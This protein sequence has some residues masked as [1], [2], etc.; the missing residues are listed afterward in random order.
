MS[1]LSSIFNRKS[2]KQE[3]SDQE[4]INKIGYVGIEHDNSIELVDKPES[5]EDPPL[6]DIP[7]ALFVEYEPPS[8]SNQLQPRNILNVKKMESNE[9][10]ETTYD[11]Q[12]LYSFLEKDYQQEGYNDALSNP[13]MSSM[14]EKVKLIRRQLDITIAKVNTS[15]SSVLRNINFHIESRSRNGMVDIVDELISKKTTIEEE[16]SKVH[17]I[18]LGAK[19][20]SGISETLIMSYKLG[21]KNGYAAISHSQL[22]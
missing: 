10:N 11:L 19:S 9:K 4:L 14:E 2:G 15:Y 7:E 20:E 13:D 17:E 12:Y 3:T 21:F 22:I 5:H 1:F 16:I 18:E 6:P 8:I